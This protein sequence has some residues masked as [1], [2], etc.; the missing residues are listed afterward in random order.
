MLLVLTVTLTIVALLYGDDRLLANIDRNS[1]DQKLESTTY[2]PALNTAAPLPDSLGIVP[3]GPPLDTSAITEITHAGDERLFIAEREG[4]IHI[5][6]PDGTV[7][8][9]AFLNIMG[10]EVSIFNWEQG[11]LGLAFHPD[12]ANNGFFYILFTANP[13]EDVRVMRYSVSANNPNIADP[14]SG[15][16]LMQIKKPLDNSGEPSE[17]HNGGSMHFGPDGY[18]YISIGKGGPDP[19]L[20]NPTPGDPNN[21]GQR[22][23]RLL[24]KILRIDVDGVN[25]DC[26]NANNG[27]PP[28]N[29]PPN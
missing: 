5:M 27:I 13:K 4:R 14:N 28:E 20:G 19:W 24:G 11:L 9:P 25:A 7:L 8:T 10:P 18:L 1:A 15:V 23:D 21:Y 16:L 26:G 12:Y 22:T 6:N 17:V 29:I 3:L 2:L